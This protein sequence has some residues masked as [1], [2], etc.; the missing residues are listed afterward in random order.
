MQRVA[1]IGVTGSGK[2][3]FAGALSSR[4]GVP[5]I[6][7][8]AFQW[9]PNWREARTADFRA[10]V[11][12]AVAAEGWVVDGNYGKARDLIWPRADT[13]VWLDYPFILTFSRM[14]RRTLRR[15]RTGEELWSGN[16]ERL[17][18]QFLSR[19]S[20]L[21]WSISTHRRHR[22]EWQ[23]ALRSD[24]YRHLRVEHFRTPSAAQAWLERV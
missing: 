22:R 8:D 14:L 24:A 15:A 4:L 10:R 7:L 20:L 2:T 3:T 17:A 21:W 5:H 12:A 19:E 18:V 13:L 1:V 23:A 16:R 6:E 9:E 11:E